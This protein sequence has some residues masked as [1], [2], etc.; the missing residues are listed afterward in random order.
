[1]VRLDYCSLQFENAEVA[2][3]N[4]EI[5]KWCVTITISFL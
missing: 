5:S 2:S 4:R 1:M 3:S